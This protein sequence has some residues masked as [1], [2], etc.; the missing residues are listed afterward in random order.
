MRGTYN[1]VQ[2]KIPKLN[3]LSFYVH[4]YAHILNLCLVNLTKQVACVRNI[5]GTLQSLNNFIK[6]SPKRNVIYE[7]CD[8]N[9]LR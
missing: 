6:S 5:F 7:S 3:P 8:H 1:G 2:A 4:C 9:H